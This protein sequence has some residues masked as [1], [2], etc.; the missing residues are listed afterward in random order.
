MNDKKN[1]QSS[2]PLYKNCKKKGKGDLKMGEDKIR[3]VDVNKRTATTHC[4]SLLQ[5]RCFG[6]NMTSYVYFRL[7]LFGHI[8]A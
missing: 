5:G 7:S 4:Y 1:L 8:L 6:Q 2:Q 3:G